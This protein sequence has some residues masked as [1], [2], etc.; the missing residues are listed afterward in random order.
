MR[1]TAFEWVIRDMDKL[2]F[3]AD[4]RQELTEYYRQDIL[5]LQDLIQR[6]LSHW[7]E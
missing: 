3:P 7:L 2:K 6:D 4:Q 1:H 5:Q